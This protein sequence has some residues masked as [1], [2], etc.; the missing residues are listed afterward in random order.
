MSTHQLADRLMGKVN[1]TESCWLWTASLSRGYGQLNVGGRPRRAHRL[2]YEML[3]G[4]VPDGLQLDHLCRNRACV[5]PAHLEPVTNRENSIRGDGPR[6][7]RERQLSKTHCKSG[8]PL[9]GD[10]IRITRDGRRACLA[11]Q[12]A[13]SRKN[14]GPRPTSRTRGPLR[15][16]VR[17]EGRLSHLECGHTVRRDSGTKPAR[18]RCAECD[19]QLSASDVPEVAA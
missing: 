4:P 17:H 12:R 16:A 7:A 5:N 14:L 13:K 3:V 9:F 1:K 11:C 10:N 8:H 19:R 15:L 18:L 6:L 2:V